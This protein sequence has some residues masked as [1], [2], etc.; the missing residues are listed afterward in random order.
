MFI[1]FSK[2]VRVNFRREYHVLQ[3]RCDR[4][5]AA[6]TKRS[7]RIDFY[8]MRDSTLGYSHDSNDY[9]QIV[10]TQVSPQGKV[11]LCK[12]LHKRFAQLFL[13]TRFVLSECDGWP[14]CF[15]QV[16]EAWQCCGCLDIR[17]TIS[18]VVNCECSPSVRRFFRTYF[19]RSAFSAVWIDIGSL[20]T[21]RWTIF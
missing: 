9:V 17:V 10:T 12:R 21:F 20:Y 13:A 1:N 5:H 11:Y 18:N 8:F 4:T 3:W 15:L 2:L 7:G 6:F 19:F 14:Q 16:Y